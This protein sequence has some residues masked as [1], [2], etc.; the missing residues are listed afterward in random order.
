M[1]MI[2]LTSAIGYTRLSRAGG[3]EEL[4]DA[5]VFL[6]PGVLATLGMNIRNDDRDQDWQ[7]DGQL[8]VGERFDQ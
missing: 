1:D 4:D 3:A 2:M 5:L 7:G 6:G 8:P